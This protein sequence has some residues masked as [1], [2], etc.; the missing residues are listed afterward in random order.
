MKS[1]VRIAV[2]TAV[3][4]LAASAARAAGVDFKDPRRA[5][6][7]EDDIK[8]DAQML[9]ETLSP[10][11][12]ISVTYQV[13]NLTPAPIA[14]ADK[15]A[16]ASFDPDSQTITVSIGAEIPQGTTMPH[17]TTI[18]PGQTRT[19]RIGASAQVL[20]AN[21]S[22]NGGCAGGGAACCGTDRVGAATPVGKDVDGAVAWACFCPCSPMP[23]CAVTG[24]APPP[25]AALP[26]GGIPGPATDFGEE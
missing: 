21:A 24:E 25:A 18:A 19:F 10:G 8:V 4:L 22:E 16:D 14:I 1:S 13:E 12:A 23:A 3:F 7:R 17:L 9:Q 5:L 26:E 6:G 20:V 11:S 2:A 15:V